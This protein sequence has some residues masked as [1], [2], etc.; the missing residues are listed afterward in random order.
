MRGMEIIQ[1]SWKVGKDFILSEV[2]CHL[3]KG[4]FYGIIG[5]NGSGK[6]SLIRSIMRFIDPTDGFIEL[7]DL[8]LLNYK[9]EHLAKKIALLPQ[10]TGINS[11]FTAK[12]IVLM[13]RSPYIKRFE[14]AKK[15]DFEKVEKAMRLCDC[16]HLEDHE[17]SNLSGGEA[18]RVLTARAIAQ[19]TD[20][21]ILDEP[22][23]SLDVKHQVELMSALVEMNQHQNK[24]IV[25]VL[26]DLNLAAQYCSDIILMKEG[27]IYFQGKAKEVLTEANLQEVYDIPFE[28]FY[29]P[30]QHRMIFMPALQ[31]RKAKNYA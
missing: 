12:E 30:L 9:R 5:P 23:A 11:S 13:G 29:H 25:A 21:L 26:H 18:Q 7:E 2:N 31:D 16:L 24:T 20:W 22:T 1:L 27:K 10:N 4:K 19:D 28:S 14:Q 8:N 17:V 15:C 3:E 6:T